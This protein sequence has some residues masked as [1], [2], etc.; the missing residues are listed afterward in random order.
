[1]SSSTPVGAIDLVLDPE[2][3][4]AR[5]RI[6]REDEAVLL[7]HRAGGRNGRDALAGVKPMPVF[8]PCRFTVKLAGVA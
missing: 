7:G 3:L 8:Q 4:F 2:L 5:H 1:M 6:P